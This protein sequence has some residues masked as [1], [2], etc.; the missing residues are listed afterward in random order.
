MAAVSGNRREIAMSQGRA[1]S[2]HISTRWLKMSTERKSDGFQ[3]SCRM[4]AT[5]QQR[6][7]TAIAKFRVLPPLTGTPQPQSFGLRD[8]RAVPL[9]LTAVRQDA[10]RH[11]HPSDDPTSASQAVKSA[12]RHSGRRPG[13]SSKDL[14]IGFRDPRKRLSRWPTC[15]ADQAINFAGAYRRSAFKIDRLISVSA[16]YKG[17]C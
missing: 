11:L 8:P 16:V 7:D 13:F 4:S 3:V 2:P 1:E 10:R 12:V 14:D 17:L 15:H 5:C 6:R 9:G